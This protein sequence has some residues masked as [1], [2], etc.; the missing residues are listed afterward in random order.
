[1]IPTNYPYYLI[2]LNSDS[3]LL[4]T[5]IIDDYRHFSIWSSCC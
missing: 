2:K 3:Y 5:Q 4:A 1:M